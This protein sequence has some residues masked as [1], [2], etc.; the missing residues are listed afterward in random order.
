MCGEQRLSS[1]WAVCSW[2]HPRVCG[3]QRGVQRP[4]VLEGG[5]PPRVRGTV[6]ASVKKKSLRGITPACAGN[7]WWPPGPASCSWDHPR[8]CG[9][10]HGG[11]TV[12]AKSVGSP[13]RVRGTASWQSFCMSENRITPAC[14]GNSGFCLARNVGRWDHP[15][16][17]GEQEVATHMA[18]LL[19]GSP[20][21]VR[22]TV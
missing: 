9:E 8:V 10:Q 21:R 2:D 6:S 3:E 4:I 18:R 5:S 12:R 11:H 15:R 22:G 13:P 14:A 20:P 1:G 17:C 16:V 7:R 19:D